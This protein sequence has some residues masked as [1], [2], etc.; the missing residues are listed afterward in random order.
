MKR[1]P[2]R[3]RSAIRL[4]SVQRKAVPVFEKL[5]DL[6]GK[7]GPKYSR[8]VQHQPTTT[9]RPGLVD[10]ETGI[11][12]RLTEAGY[13]LPVLGT[14]HRTGKARSKASKYKQKAERKA[15]AIARKKSSFNA[16]L[17]RASQRVR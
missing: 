16:T 2:L 12:H 5:V 7:A 15:K 11:E 1:H 9:K 4:K 6:E 8:P 3:L 17:A 14:A 13:W 10:S